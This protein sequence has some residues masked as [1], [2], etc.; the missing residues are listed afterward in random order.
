VRGLLVVFACGCTV[1]EPFGPSD[2]DESEVASLSLIEPCATGQWCIEAPPA[3]V[4]NTRLKAV[5]AGDENDVFAV[6][7][8]GAILRRA[9]GKDWST[10]PSGTGLNLT[11]VWGSSSS[12]VWVGTT[13]STVL[14]YDGTSWAQLSAPIPNVDSIW[15]SSPND[16]WLIGS[17]VTMHWNGSAFSAA[18]GT[19]ALFSVSGTGSNDAWIGG[20]GVYLRHWNGTAWKTYFPQLS[21]STYRAVFARTPSDAWAAGVVPKFEMTHWDG[22]KWTA[23]RTDVRGAFMFSISGQSANDVW[24]VGDSGTILHYDGKSWSSIFTMPAVPDPSTASAAQ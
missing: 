18:S 13:S 21:G 24:A 12:D 8:E 7:D 11:C 20:S 10:M 6:G 16:I 17:G 1:T 15:G 5:W 14:H 22:A 23:Y 4:A 9:N 3:G 2:P 19:T